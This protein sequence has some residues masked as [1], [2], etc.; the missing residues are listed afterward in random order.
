MSLT[1]FG[2]EAVLILVAHATGV[3]PAAAY[4]VACAAAALVGLLL[5]RAR[6][7]T[8]ITDTFQAQAYGDVV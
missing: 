5:V 7:A 4:L 6:L 2:T 1:L 3:T 8:L